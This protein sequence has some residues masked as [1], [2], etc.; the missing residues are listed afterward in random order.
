MQD[1]TKGDEA[2]IKEAA[3]DSRHPSTHSRQVIQDEPSKF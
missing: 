2:R 1:T 3:G